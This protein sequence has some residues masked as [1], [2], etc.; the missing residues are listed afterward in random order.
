MKRMMTIIVAIAILF[1]LVIVTKGN[2]T[3]AEEADVIWLKKNYDEVSE[4]SKDITSS[5]FKLI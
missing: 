4:F 1:N 3:N 2:I 5:P